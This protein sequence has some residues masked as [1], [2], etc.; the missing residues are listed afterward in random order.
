MRILASLYH[1]VGSWPFSGAERR[2]CALT[3]KWAELGVETVALEPQPFARDRM[4]GGYSV[5]RVPLSSRGLFRQ[6]A[7]WSLRAMSSGL[8]LAR[9]ARFD[10]VYAAN[11]NIF[12]LAVSLGIADRLSLPCVAVV[13]HLRWVDYL[14]DTPGSVSGRF[15]ALRFLN[16]IVGE[17]L[18]VPASI[19]R[20]AAASAEVSLLR[21]F[22]GFVTVSEVIRQQLA[23]FV[24]PNRVFVVRNAVTEGAVIHQPASDRQKLALFVGRLDEGKGILDLIR[25]WDEVRAT[26]QEA[27]LAIVGEGSL[28]HRAEQEVGRRGLRNS[29]SLHGFVGDEDVAELLRQARLFVTF[30]RTEGFGIA[31]AE[32]LSNGLPVVAWNIPPLREIFGSC[33]S[34]ILIPTGDVS[35]AVAAIAKVL[36]LP[37]AQWLALSREASKYTPRFSWDEA[38]T[39]ELRALETILEAWKSSHQTG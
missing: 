20:A 7:E 28:R 13:H 37:H 36:D 11:N 5:A 39:R 29:I 24:S 4:P 8:A 17:G 38:A 2:F 31:I 10:L 16:Y 23:S 15:D 27:R 22:F 1:P 35:A 25:T 21:R 9:N 26:S 18:S 19:A 32:A 33:P 3:R 34:A 14:S 12:N 6:F 30:S